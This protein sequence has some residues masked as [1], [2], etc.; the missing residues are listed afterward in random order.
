MET[1]A[2][3]SVMLRP[4]WLSSVEVRPRGSIAPVL[5]S[6][7]HCECEY[8]TFRTIFVLDSF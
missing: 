3:V 4:E 8:L 7:R 6:W 2:A 1:A 5:G